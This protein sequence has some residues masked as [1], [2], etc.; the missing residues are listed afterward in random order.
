MAAFSPSARCRASS[1]DPRNS[2]KWRPAGDDDPL[3]LLEAH[4]RE[5]TCGYAIQ[6]DGDGAM[7]DLPRRREVDGTVATFDQPD[8][9]P[10]LQIGDCAADGRLRGAEFHNGGAVAQVP[11]GALE[12]LPGARRERR[13]LM[14]CH[15]LKSSW[16]RI[17]TATLLKGEHGN[18]I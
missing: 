6:A 10:A 7:E 5:R 16:F 4:R 17:D 2:S 12:N 14:R 18:Q 15:Q 8:R 13:V 11:R 9:E 3:V 1:R